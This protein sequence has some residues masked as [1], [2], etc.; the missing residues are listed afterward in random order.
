LRILF[1]SG[2]P[3]NALEDN[4][5]DKDS[6]EVIGKPYRQNVLAQRIRTILD[7]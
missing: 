6:I 1:T 5:M 2:Y 3:E 4:E 7:N